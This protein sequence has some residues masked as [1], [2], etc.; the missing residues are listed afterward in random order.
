MAAVSLL[1][2]P[3][4]LQLLWSP[5]GHGAMVAEAGAK[6]GWTALLLSSAAAGWLTWTARGRIS[7]P[8]A[9]VLLTVLAAMA[10]FAAVGWEHGNWVAYHAWMAGQTAAA[11]AMLLLGWWVQRTV[12]RVPVTVGREASEID[13]ATGLT[14]ESW[15]S[16][17]GFSPLSH[18]TQGRSERIRR[19]PASGRRARGRVPDERGIPLDVDRDEAPHPRPLP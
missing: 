1:A 19:L 5:A 14:S 15:R 13:V 6:W 8:F 7:I 2:L 9:G 16:M 11:G 17:P 12:V 3:A 18:C 10:A 4:M